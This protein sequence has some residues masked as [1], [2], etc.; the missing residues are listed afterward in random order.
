MLSHKKRNDL[1]VVNGGISTDE[2]EHV[3]VKKVLKITPTYYQ[4][5]WLVC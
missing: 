5:Y 4:I 1:N 2:A 3:M